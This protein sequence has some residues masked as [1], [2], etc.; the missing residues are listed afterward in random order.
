MAVPST[1]STAAALDAL[2]AVGALIAVGV[3]MAEGG[4][5]CQTELTHSIDT[6]GADTIT[7]VVVGAGDATADTMDI[8]NGQTLGK[9]HKGVVF[10]GG[11]KVREHQTKGN[12]ENGTGVAHGTDGRW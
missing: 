12:G 2:V 5:A 4:V 9:L 7:L 8:G 6:T 10:T 11:G 1:S 3:D